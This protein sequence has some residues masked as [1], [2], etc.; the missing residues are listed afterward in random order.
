MCAVLYS[1]DPEGME[2][3]NKEQRYFATKFDLSVTKY[4]VGLG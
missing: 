4:E 3:L 2:I 1:D